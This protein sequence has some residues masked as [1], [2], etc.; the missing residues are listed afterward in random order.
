MNEFSATL[1]PEVKLHPGKAKATPSS[2]FYSLIPHLINVL[3][4]LITFCFWG[5]F[6]SI[7]NVVSNVNSNTLVTLGYM[8]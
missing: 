5:C 3:S 1:C 2:I 8:P 6:E 4:S 7:Q